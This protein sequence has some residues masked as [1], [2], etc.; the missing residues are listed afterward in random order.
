[1]SELTWDKCSAFSSTV[2]FRLNPQLACRNKA[3]KSDGMLL[4]NKSIQFSEVATNMSEASRA[5][6]WTGGPCLRRGW[7]RIAGKLKHTALIKHR[8]LHKP[9]ASPSV[10]HRQRARTHRTGPLHGFNP[11]RIHQS[12]ALLRWD[13]PVGHARERAA[14]QTIKKRK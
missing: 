13:W 12:P 5:S 8:E 10:P 9:F 11:T 7:C 14:D 4:K 2:T 1:M 6:L 3:K